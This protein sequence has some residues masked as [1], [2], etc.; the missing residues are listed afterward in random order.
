MRRA[1]GVEV[2]LSMFLLRKRR[3]EWVR[4]ERAAV[5]KVRVARRRPIIVRYWKCQP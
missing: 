2:L 3:C 4:S 1:R 5:T